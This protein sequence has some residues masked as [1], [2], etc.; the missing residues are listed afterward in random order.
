M[1]WFELTTNLSKSRP[2]FQKRLVNSCSGQFN[3]YI[4]NSIF[5]IS[6][7][8]I[9]LIFDS[10]WVFLYQ[11]PCSIVWY[12]AVIL[13]RSVELS[14]LLIQSSLERQLRLIL[15]LTSYLILASV[16]NHLHLTVCVMFL[17]F[18]F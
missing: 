3:W 2:F 11:T 9:Y 8:L 6:F 17:K 14:C 5:Q 16:R 1:N 15:T 4:S 13:C 12:I 10:Y 7:F 18:H